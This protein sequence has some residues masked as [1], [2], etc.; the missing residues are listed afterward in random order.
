L[1]VSESRDCVAYYY[2][3]KR[4]CIAGPIEAGDTRWEPDFLKNYV[5]YLTDKAKKTR[6]QQRIR[7]E[8]VDSSTLSEMLGIVDRVIRHGD[9]TEF[10]NYSKAH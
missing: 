9:N 10:I 6:T 4:H 7:K 3:Q 2:K 5:L 8:I 1:K